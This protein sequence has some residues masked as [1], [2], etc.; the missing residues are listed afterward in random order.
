MMGRAFS[1]PSNGLRYLIGHAL[2]YSDHV[3]ICSPWLSDVDVR[4][5][6][7]PGVD[8]RRTKLAAAIKELD[9]TVDV[10]VLPDQSSND[11][12]LSRLSRIDNVTVSTVSD[13]HAKAVVTD[14]YVYAGSA[15]ITRG[16]LITNKELCKVVE[17]EYGDV[18]SYVEAELEV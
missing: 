16:G 11:Y 8:D 9:T 10:Y 3:A 7:A 4:L 18:R 6:L 13:L 17:N 2:V 15:N 14:L 1:L 5:P 12:A